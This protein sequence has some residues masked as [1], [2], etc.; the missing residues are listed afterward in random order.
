MQTVGLPYTRSV[1]CSWWII[2]GA[3]PKLLVHCPHWDTRKDQS[4]YYV[5]SVIY[6]S[7][8]VQIY[9]LCK[10]QLIIL[11]KIWVVILHTYIFSPFILGT[12]SIDGD[13][14]ETEISRWRSFFTPTCQSQK[15][16]G[17]INN[18]NDGCQSLNGLGGGPA[19]TAPGAPNGMECGRR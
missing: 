14:A 16:T 9:T 11:M 12:N 2:L 4:Y 8:L 1:L 13:V 3:A 7:H 10:L 6:L 5:N 18:F 17:A 15:H 19:C